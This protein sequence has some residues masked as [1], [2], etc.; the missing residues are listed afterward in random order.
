MSAVEARWRAF[1]LRDLAAVV[2]LRSA[3]KHVSEKKA[4]KTFFHQPFT[5]LLITAPT[6]AINSSSSSKFLPIFANSWLPPQTSAIFRHFAMALM[7][8]A[9]VAVVGLSPLASVNSI[10]SK[11][12]WGINSV[13]TL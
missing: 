3:R 10:M 4:E 6:D 2:D 13:R 12:T 9:K 1:L 7:A 8:E 11:R 5:S